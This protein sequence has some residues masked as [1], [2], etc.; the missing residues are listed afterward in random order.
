MTNLDDCLA[1][2]DLGVDLIG[3]VFYGKS[4]RYVAPE[5]VRT[6]IGRLDGAVKTVGVFV[7][8][9]ECDVDRLMDLCGLDYA[10]VYAAQPGR[11]RILAYRVNGHI[12]NVAEKGL[13]LFDSY[14]S[15]FGGSGTPFDVGLLKGHS[16]LGRAFIA[17]GINEENVEAV[18][19]LGPF[20]IDFVSSVERHKG[21]KDLSKMKRLVNRIRRFD[22]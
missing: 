4:M 8:E 21:K 11:N 3:F 12:P 2:A 5:A 7:E 13:V 18:L 16:A 19:A 20:G 22:I 10:Q 1:A 9:P 6:I 17:G 14:S 15:G